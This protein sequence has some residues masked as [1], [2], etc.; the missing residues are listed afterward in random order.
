MRWWATCCA[1]AVL[2]G[3]HAWLTADELRELADAVLRTERP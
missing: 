2:A 1:V 3:F